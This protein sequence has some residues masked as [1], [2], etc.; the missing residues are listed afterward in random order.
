MKNSTIAST[1]HEEEQSEESE[2]QSYVSSYVVTPASAASAASLE[3][4]QIYVEYEIRNTG[5][6]FGGVI[7]GPEVRRFVVVGLDC[8]SA[9]IRVLIIRCGWIRT[10]PIRAW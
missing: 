10:M 3:E 7:G 5:G 9:K 4:R 1:L 2:I 8:D 6:S